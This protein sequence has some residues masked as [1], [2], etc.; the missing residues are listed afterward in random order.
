VTPQI[1][2]GTQQAPNNRAA[3]TAPPLGADEASSPARGWS[4]GYGNFEVP[5]PAY[6][7]WREAISRGQA[8]EAE[9][10]PP[11]WPPRSQPS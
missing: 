1:G 3:C 4:G 5:Q 7:H 10:D 6:D 2:Y 9:W 8:A 11:P